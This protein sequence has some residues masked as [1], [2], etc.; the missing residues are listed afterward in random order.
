MNKTFET[1]VH[2]A[3]WKYELVEVS[4]WYSEGSYWVLFRI[5]RILAK[6]AVN[7]IHCEYSQSNTPKL[8]RTT[9][10]ITL[11]S[12]LFLNFEED[13]E[14]ILA[15]EDYNQM[16]LV[17]QW[18]SYKFCIF[19]FHSCLFNLVFICGYPR[20]AMLWPFVPMDASFSRLVIFKWATETYDSGSYTRRIHS[21]TWVLL[22]TGSW[23][24]ESRVGR[25]LK[26]Y[27]SIGN[28]FLALALRIWSMVSLND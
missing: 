8:I 25:F 16:D 24:M 17:S 5:R 4:I 21:R 26:A 27:L 11:L 6:L 13:F 12:R 15:G 9:H 7:Q 3:Y 1:W 18:L 22:K 20:T 28:Y 23:P 19:D 2:W 14:V 10:T